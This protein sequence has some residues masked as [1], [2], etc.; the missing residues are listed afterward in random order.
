MKRMILNKPKTDT[1]FKKVTFY[2][3][4]HTENSIVYEPKVITEIE[5]LSKIVSCCFQKCSMNFLDDFI[6]YHRQ[7]ATFPFIMNI[8]SA[9]LKK[10]NPFL[11]NSFTNYFWF[12]CKVTAE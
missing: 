6:C 7:P 2:K 11:N 10:C 12:V 5:T 9:I 3:T 8:S 1:K 4:K